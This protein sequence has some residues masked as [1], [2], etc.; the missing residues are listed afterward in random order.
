MRLMDQIRGAIRL[1]HYSFRTE[2]SYVYWIKKFIFF[3]GT[4][5]PQE[6]GENEIR[7]FLSHLATDKNVSASTQNQALFAILFLYRAVLRQPCEWI[8]GI[9]RARRPIHIPVVFTRQEVRTVLSLLGPGSKWIMGNLLYGA[10]LRLMECLSLRVKDIDFDYS[11]LIIRDGKGSK[12]RVTMLPTI[13]KEPLKIQLQKVKA[14]H[15]TDLK[16]GYG[17]V[18]LP[19]RVKTKYPK[20]ETEFGWQY[21]FPSS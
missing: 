18:W 9:E 11:Q 20:A 1:R 6:M 13:T 2:Q 5:H 3:N 8:E 4:R 17:R 7:R 15:D 21:A 10:G 16:E 12:D 14:L 19:Y